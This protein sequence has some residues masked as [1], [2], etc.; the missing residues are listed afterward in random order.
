MAQTDKAVILARGL[1]TRMK[2]ADDAAGLNRQE[3]AAADTGVKAL[4]PIGRPFL[5]YVL[6]G[7][8]QA[9]YRRVCLVVAPDHEP[10]R[11]YYQ[12]EAPPE[13]L[14]IDFAVQTEPKGTA[15]AVLAAERFA[16][17]EPVVMLNSD[18]YYPPQALRAL[19]DLAT[20]G[21]ALF[22]RESGLR[23]VDIG[24]QDLDPHSVALLDED[25]DTV[26]IVHFA[27]EVCGNELRWMMRL[28]PCGL[29]GEDGVPG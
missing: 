6:T 29:V 1:G 28:E 18:N 11:R 14:S 8:S 9:G 10:F 27:C 7:L 17:G 12:D 24:R 2:A 3:A 5:D 19:R 16:D 20:P 15:D 22:D 25:D 21:L 4:I 23:A 26:G 13:T